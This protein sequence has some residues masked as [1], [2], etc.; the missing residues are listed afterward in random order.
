MVFN[1]W[2]DSYYFIYEFIEITGN[3]C[4]KNKN[5]KPWYVLNSS[6]FKNFQWWSNCLK[7]KNK[8]L[9]VSA[10]DYVFMFKDF[11]RTVSVYLLTHFLG[12]YNGALKF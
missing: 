10:W 8:F 7:L 12:T 11:Q 4:I 2:D 5:R 3:N 6:V 1:L 9:L